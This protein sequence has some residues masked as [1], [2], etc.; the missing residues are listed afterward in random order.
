MFLNSE[1]RYEI[2]QSIQD[3]RRYL[4]TKWGKK[5]VECYFLKYGAYDFHDLWIITFFLIG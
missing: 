1:G 2:L 4:N 3:Q 5:P